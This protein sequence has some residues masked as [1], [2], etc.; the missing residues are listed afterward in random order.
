MSPVVSSVSYN[1]MGL[2]LVKT[3]PEEKALRYNQIYNRSPKVLQSLVYSETEALKIKI[4]TQS[5]A[6]TAWHSLPDVSQHSACPPFVLKCPLHSL[7]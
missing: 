3:P 5:Y 1:S 6:L 2:K 4:R 7:F